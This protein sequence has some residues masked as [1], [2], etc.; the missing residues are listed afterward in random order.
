[1]EHLNLVL[2]FKLAGHGD[3]QIR[4]AARIEVD[5]EGGLIVYAAGGQPSERI[6]V[7]AVQSLSIQYVS[8]HSCRSIVRLEPALAY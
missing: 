6:D 1:M 8:G 7:A 5:S 4:A 3:Y 2:T